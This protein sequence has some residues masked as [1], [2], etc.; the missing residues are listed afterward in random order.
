MNKC[1]FNRE[2]E[3]IGNGDELQAAFKLGNGLN[4]FRLT[5]KKSIEL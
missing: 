4:T 3:R 1:R 2:P 5:G